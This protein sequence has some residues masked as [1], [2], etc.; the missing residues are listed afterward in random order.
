MANKKIAASLTKDQKVKL[1]DNL[2]TSYPHFWDL[3]TLQQIILS[4]HIR[5][6]IDYY[7]NSDEKKDSLL[8]KTLKP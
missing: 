3:G 1:F 8:T 6:A 4:C 2:F 5:F 7:I